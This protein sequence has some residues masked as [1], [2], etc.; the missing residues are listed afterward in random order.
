MHLAKDLVVAN[1]IKMPN[2]GHIVKENPKF[3]NEN[4]NICTEGL[5]SIHFSK[6]WRNCVCFQI[7][8][9]FIK[10]GNDLK[11]VDILPVGNHP[12]YLFFLKAL[13]YNR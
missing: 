11:T 7:I 3:D 5:Q 9:Y 8:K 4:T 10:S 12:F 2:M 1:Y 13:S 6:I